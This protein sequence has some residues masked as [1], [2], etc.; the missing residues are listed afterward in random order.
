MNP[1][2][3]VQVPRR[4]VRHEWGGTETVVFETSKRL[5]AMGNDCE[6]ICPNALAEQNYEFMEGIRIMRTPYFYPYWGLSEESRRQLDK[7]GGNM[8]SFSL[9]NLLL[10]IPAL[11]IIHLHTGNRIGGIGRFA[12][13]RRRIPYL[14]SL[15]GGMFDMP[16][17]EAASLT[18]PA[19]GSFEWG[20][21]LGW[22]VGS[23][24]VLDDA[25][26]I[27]CVG[28][29]EQ[30]LVQ[31]RYPNK[32]VEYLP[33]GVDLTKFRAGDGA[34]FRRAH[35][36]PP[37]ARLYMTVG[38]IDPQKNQA[39][40][41]QALR[42]LRETQPNAHWAFMGP[43]T[44]ETYR[45]SLLRDIRESGLENVVRMIPGVSQG[46]P[47]LCDA[48]R[49]ADVFVLPSIHEPFGIVVLEAWAA[50]LPVIA[51]NVGGVPHVITH[52]EEGLLFDPRDPYSLAQTCRDLTPEHARRLAEK[53]RAKAER[54]FTWDIIA[55]RLLKIY[56]EVI[57]AYPVR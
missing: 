26:A 45:Q 44:N 32:R 15:H 11:H 4:F 23:R 54:E 55:A 6:I 40:A 42:I 48:Y 34:R 53:G 14:I 2:H 51:A 27:V 57:D 35:D 5:V 49:A 50:G 17:D 1:I 30:L 18:A 7:K 25:A 29:G 31:R 12:A 56:E 22:C 16:K 21:A 9:L 41:I 36:I 28:K 8:F 46:D 20:K 19:R 33:N 43:V 13:R 24:R 3:S 39:T 47:A 38:R 52:G 10:H 37:D